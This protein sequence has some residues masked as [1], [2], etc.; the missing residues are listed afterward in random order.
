[1]ISNF[2]IVFPLAAVL[3]FANHFIT[4]AIQK[5]RLIYY[6]R[7]I[8]STSRLSPPFLFPMLDLLTNFAVVSNAG[9]IVFTYPN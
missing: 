1:L 4:N 7:R 8:I 5:R 2:A 3:T 6:T 9:L